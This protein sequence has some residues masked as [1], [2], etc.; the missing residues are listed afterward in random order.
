MQ[1]PKGSQGEPEAE[2]GQDWGCGAGREERD[3]FLVASWCSRPF[4]PQICTV[5]SPRNRF[6]IGIAISPSPLGRLLRLS[7]LWSWSR[8]VGRE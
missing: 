2:Q 6:M 1:H 4:K 8:I 5:Q 7:T 3:Q